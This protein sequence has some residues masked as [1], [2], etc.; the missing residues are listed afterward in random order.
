MRFR[1]PKRPGRSERKPWPGWVEKKPNRIWIY[2]ATHW[3]T[4]EAASVV[5]TDVVEPVSVAV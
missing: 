3:K 2:D 1:R 4:S 5:I